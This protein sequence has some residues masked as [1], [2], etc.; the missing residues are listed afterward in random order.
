MHFVTPTSSSNDTESEQTELITSTPISTS[1]NTDSENETSLSE[2]LHSL[3]K[4]ELT[5]QLKVAAEE[6]KVLRRKI[7]EFEFSIQAKSGKMLSKEE[8]APIEHIYTAYK[9]TK[10]RLK[11]LEA[12]VSKK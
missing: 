4:S 9:A 2:K 10:G 3:S 1:N 6:K 7:K 12:L 5:Q 11:L 8:K